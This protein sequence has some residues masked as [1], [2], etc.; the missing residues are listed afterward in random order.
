MTIAS[1]TSRITYSGDGATTT[2]AVPFYFALN[3][4][5]VVYLRATNGTQTLVTLGTDYQLTGSGVSTGGTLTMTVAPSSI[6]QLIIYRDP[7]ITQTTSYNNNDPFPAKSHEAALDKLTAIMQRLTSKLSRFITLPETSPVSSPTTTDPVPGQWIRWN[8]AGTGIESSAI[9]LPTGSAAIAT[10]S[11]AD[12]GVSNIAMMTPL[13]SKQSAPL[14]SSRAAA[15]ATTIPAAATYIQTAGYT[16]AGDGGGS[17]YVRGS[18]SGSFT[19]AGSVTWIPVVDPRGSNPIV[20]GA[21]GDGVTDDSAAINNLI[22]YLWATYKGGVINFP[23]RT[24]LIASSIL[25]RPQTT[26]QGYI[27]DGGQN[28]NN[29]SVINY[30]GVTGSAII[31]KIPTAVIPYPTIRNLTITGLNSVG[32]VIDGKSFQWALIAD[33]TVLSNSTDT[34]IGIRVSSAK[35]FALITGI[36]QANPAIVTAANHGLSNGQTVGISGVVG[37]TQVNARSYTVSSVTTNTF[38]IGID[39]TGYTAYSSG[40]A[41]TVF[42]SDSNYNQIIGN[43]IGLAKIGIYLTDQFNGSLVEFN[44][45]QPFTAVSAS[46][47]IFIDP[48]FVNFPNGLTMRANNIETNSAGVTGIYVGPMVGNGISINNNRFEL[49]G[50]TC[51]AVTYLGSVPY[52][53][54]GN[55]Y[56][57]GASFT[58]LNDTLNLAYGKDTALVGWRVV[59]GAAANT[60]ISGSQFNLTTVTKT[61]TGD[62]TFF[63]PALANTIRFIPKITPAGGAITCYI[64]SFSTTQLHV[65]CV[66]RTGAASDPTTLYVEVSGQ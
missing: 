59:Y 65:L 43:Y 63:Y 31:G 45:I 36:T 57:G 35:L 37:M 1:Q 47:G 54:N 9:V 7:P 41:A 21:V 15:I 12:A 42:T 32:P 61:G 16:T 51:T 11:E 22:E 62:Y 17:M 13:R 40:G 28:P 25:I 50:S 6:L 24:F 49:P 34:S 44:R 27:R 38:S 33:N 29:V 30:T 2:F 8:A 3:S 52:A 66:D 60:I 53:V 64:S 48:T 20:F 10:Q 26:L 23:Q 4:D 39:S 55:N 56:D 46:Y 18:G 14:F 58:V 5:I 19:D